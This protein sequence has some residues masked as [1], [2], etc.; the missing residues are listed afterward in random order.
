MRTQASAEALKNVF[1]VSALGTM[2]QKEFSKALLQRNAQMLDELHT[3]IADV[4]CKQTSS[5]SLSLLENEGNVQ[6]AHCSWVQ[7]RVWGG[8]SSGV[9]RVP[10]TKLLFLHPGATPLD[11]ASWH[12]DRPSAALVSPWAAGSPPSVSWRH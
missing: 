8:E 2:A 12:R 11:A 9:W 4:K 1:G 10:I 3:G 5:A 7:S 6:A